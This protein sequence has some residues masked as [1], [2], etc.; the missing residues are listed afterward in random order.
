LLALASAA[1]AAGCYSG[2]RAERDINDAWQGRQVAEIENEWGRAEP[3]DRSDEITTLAWRYVRVR[4]SL[5][6][7]GA[8]LYA[9][10]GRVEGYAAFEPGRVHRRVTEVVAFAGDDGVI[11]EV[12]GPSLRW[13]PPNEANIHW[14]VLLGG[15]VGMGRLDDTSTPLPSGGLYIGGMVSRTTG[16]VGAFSM[17]SGIGDGGGAMGFAW[18]FAAQHWVTARLSLRGGPAAIL[19]FD[20]GFEKIGAEPGINGA[21]SYAVLKAG[22]FALDLR[23]DLVA[24]A[25][26]RFGSAGIGVNLN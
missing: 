7:G 19:A 11:R 18:A 16:L 21:V 26:N 25:D 1:L 22:T 3:V 14:G 10:P 5:P 13:G 23:L 2:V 15:H 9:E 4:R 24:G 12:R 6:R 20:P 17:V 8:A